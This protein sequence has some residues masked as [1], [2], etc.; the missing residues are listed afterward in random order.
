MLF[1]TLNIPYL[2]KLMLYLVATYSNPAYH[3]IAAKRVANAQPALLG[4]S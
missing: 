1:H 2:D 4:A 3:A